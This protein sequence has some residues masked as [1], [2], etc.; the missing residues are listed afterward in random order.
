MGKGCHVFFAVAAVTASSVVFASETWY[1]KSVTTCVADG[2]GSYGYSLTSTNNWVNAVS[3]TNGL[4]VSGD[5][6]IIDTTK[7]S[8]AQNFGYNFGTGTAFGGLIYD[9]APSGNSS[10]QGT[11]TLQAGGTGIVAN[12]ALTGETHKFNGNVA[13][14]GSGDAVVDLRVAGTLFVQK[15]FYGNA[16]ITLV[17]KGVGTLQHSDGYAPL[18]TAKTA[19]TEARDDT[20][21]YYP[22][23]KFVFGGVK[24]QGGVLD[25][26]QYYWIWNCD[27]QFDGD[28]AG[29]SVN[30]LVA[31]LGTN[32]LELSGCKFRE[33]ENVTGTSHYVTANDP[34][35]FIHFM[36]TMDD[37]SFSGL[38]KGS[39]GICWDPANTATFTFRKSISPTTG[40]L[41]VSNGTVRVTEDAGFTAL[42]SVTVS[43]ANSR[44]KVEADALRS[45]PAPFFL[46][47]GGK[48][49]VADGIVIFV[50]SLAVDGTPVAAGLYNGQA[51]L[52]GTTVAWI[53]GAGYVVVTGLTEGTRTDATWTGTGS[54]QTPANWNGASEL[55]AL[56][57]ATSYVTVAESAADDSV[58]HLDRIVWFKGM[59]VKPVGFQTT[60]DAGCEL[61]LGS[62]GLATPAAQTFSLNAPTR[63]TAAQDWAIGAGGRLVVG[64]S[65][66]TLPAGELRILGAG[67]GT[68]ELNA[69]ASDW[70]AP[71][72]VSNLNVQFNASHALGPQTAPFATIYHNAVSGSPAYADGVTVDRNLLFVD[73]SR[74]IQGTT[75]ITV[76][77]N[78]NIVFNG[79]VTTT[80]TSNLALS[81]GAG[82]TVTFNDLFMSRDGGS[83][84]GSGTMIFNGPYHCRDR[85][86]MSGGTMELHATLNRFNGNMGIWNNGTIKTMVPYAV[87]AGN[88]TRRF[89][90]EGVPNNS[91]DGSQRTWLNP[92]GSAVLDLCGNDQSVDQ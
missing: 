91:V 14:T 56:N 78:A 87:E 46:N 25:L 40:I 79:V 47:G 66:S 82:S 72:A 44:F 88:A 54:V 8:P 33:T 81:S 69:G 45:I 21:R 12:A 16:N 60:A 63:L 2:T 28:G 1:W 51:G 9:T 62:L 53:D 77:E 57:G 75:R 7:Y 59:D 67:G 92:Y 89:T 10:D 39:A 70:M 4:P 20:T 18:N 76:P 41:A 42:S 80:N 30:K 23:R 36:G 86:N 32:S 11:F 68:L 15:A 29:L 90:T 84:S 26:R 58:M 34:T 38:F 83:V 35:C 37:T 85:F 24:L 17:K 61:W 22:N 64:A 3:G 71:I 6:V 43:G 50:A 49:G 74:V 65:V 31:N 13:F 52:N 48:I 73:T 55:P 19:Y 5:I 27:F